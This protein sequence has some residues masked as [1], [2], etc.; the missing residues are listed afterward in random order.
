[1]SLSNSPGD[2]HFN[3]V[4]RVGRTCPWP[5]LKASF[6]SVQ[7]SPKAK[8]RRTTGAAAYLH[9]ALQA[10]LPSGTFPRP[11]GRE[12]EEFLKWDDWR[13]LG[14]LAAGDGAEHGRRLRE[15]DHFREVYHT[16]ETPRSEHLR[17]LERVRERLGTLV[18]AEGHPE[19]SW[20]KL[21]KPDIPIISDN[22]GRAVTPLSQHSEVVA[23]LSPT[24]TVMLF[25][26]KEDVEQ[27]REQVEAILGTVP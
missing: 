24:G 12:L 20:Y 27:A 26:R 9:G 10:M 2:K 21:G 18:Q 7:P 13:V 17:Q 11:V 23:R 5:V 1:M 22:P 6:H 3:T 4:N 16:P 25:C 14:A 19:K 15:R 8:C